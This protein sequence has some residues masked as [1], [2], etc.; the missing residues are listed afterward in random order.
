MMLCK[1][2]Y[3]RTPVGISKVATVLSQEAR[4]NSTPF[5]CGQCINCRIN[6]G[7][8][9]TNRILL[10]AKCHET[11]CFV[12]LTYS[13]EDLPDNSSLKR[14]DVTGFIKRLRERVRPRQ[15]RYYYCGEYGSR[16]NRP[17][18]H[19]AIFG[20]SVTDE[21]AIS[22]SWKKGHVMVGDLS[23]SSA[24]YVAGYVLKKLKDEERM[25]DISEDGE[26]L[27]RDKE[28]S[29]MSLRP[30]IG[31]LA[32]DKI[33]KRIKDKVGRIEKFRLGKK[34][35]FLGRTLQNRLDMALDVANDGVSLYEYQ[36]ELFD[37]FMDGENLF[38]DN[39]LKGNAQKRLNQESRSKI[40][41][42]RRKI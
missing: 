21:K 23:S 25:Y 9:W 19:M 28:F 7:R 12:T 8:L 33:A 38:V 18:Y 6:R 22:G 15:I 29:G 13:D 42:K 31:G 16:T 14:C 2:P 1:N 5:P 27:E 24:R 3:V 20:L 10:E 41:N 36:S 39:L 35:V 11:S 40:Y 4:E 32:I 30:P 34:D 26:I 17:H 37:Q